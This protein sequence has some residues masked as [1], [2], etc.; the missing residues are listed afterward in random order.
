MSYY[1]GCD[2][3]DDLGDSPEIKAIDAAYAERARVES[4]LAALCAEPSPWYVLGVYHA[5]AADATTVR[6]LAT[7]KRLRQ[8]QRIDVRIAAL[9]L[10][11]ND[12]FPDDVGGYDPDAVIDAEWHAR[13]ADEMRQEIA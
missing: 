1:P 13:E 2:D 10:D 5:N 6:G 7:D 12:E 3:N 8:L 4:E 9:L 11:I